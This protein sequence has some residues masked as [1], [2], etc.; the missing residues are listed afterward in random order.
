MATTKC[1]MKNISEFCKIVA[2]APSMAQ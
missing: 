1:P 2:M